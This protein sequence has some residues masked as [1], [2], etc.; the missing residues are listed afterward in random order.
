MN[1]SSFAI[2]Q[3]TPRSIRNTPEIMLHFPSGFKIANEENCE[4]LHILIS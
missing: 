1:I 4:S 2:I 3:K